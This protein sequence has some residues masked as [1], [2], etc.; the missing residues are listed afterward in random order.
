MASSGSGGT[1]TSLSAFISSLIVNLIV[2]AVFLIIFVSLRKKQARVYEPRTTVE[3]VPADLVPDENPRGAFSW[4]TH[5]LKKPEAFIIQQA[6]VDGYFFIRFLFEFCVVCYGGAIITWPILFPV[7]AT[8]SNHLTEFNMLAFGNVKHKWRYLAHIFMS[9]IFFGFVLFLIYRELVY[10]TTFR[11]VVQT[12]PLYDSLLSSRTLL[13]TEV[14]ENALEEGEL[15]TYFPTATNV[16]YARDYAELDEKVKERTKL[17]SKYEGALNKVISTAVKTRAK[18]IKKNKEPPS[19]VDDINK[20]LKDGKK[21]PT[22]RLKFLIGKKVDTLNYGAERLGE[23]NKEIKKNQ[24]ECHANTQIPSV[25]IEFPTQLELQKAY[26]A[27][28][29]NTDFKNTKRH[30]GLAPDDVI[31]EN[32]SL[33]TNKRRIKKII[34]NVVLTLMIIFWAIPVAVVGAISNINFLISKVHFLSFINNLPSFLLGLITGL[35]PVVALAI[36]MSL[37]PPFIRKMGKVAGCITVQ[38]VESFCQAWYYAFQVVHVFLV[39]TLA[40]SATSVVTAVIDEPSSA[41][42]LLAEKIPPASN[43]YI[44]YLCLQGLAVSSGL[45]VQIV[46]LILSQFLGKILDSTP[47]AKWTRWNTLG[48]PAWSTVYPAYQLLVV[49]ALCYAVIAPLVLGFTAVAFTLI[50]FAYVYTLTYVLQPNKTDARGRNYPSALFQMF[51]G[52]YL[53]EVCLLAMFVFTK[54]WVCVALE[55]VIL[56]VTIGCHV[57]YKRIF[58]PL[59]DIVPISALKYASGDNTFQYP[60]H[61]QGLKEIKSEGENY[62]QGGNQLGLTGDHA[63]QVLPHLDNSAASGPAASTLDNH[64]T[65]SRKPINDK[66]SDEKLAEPTYETK[67]STTTAGESQEKVKPVGWISR[68]FHP[69][70]ESFD[71]LRKVMPQVLFNYIEYND[72]FI[73]TAYEDPAVNDDEPHIWIPRDELGLSEIQKNLALEQGVDVSDGNAIFNEKNSIEYTGPPPSYEE[74]LKI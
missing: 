36:L 25:F 10:Y 66:S 24:L 40:S 64:S 52:L 12:T 72:D 23:L 32:L 68:F 44:A 11:H 15:R 60:S 67:A 73:K 69:K 9:W 18:A 70:T 3:T 7:N 30:T 48:Q 5:V 17:A 27:I 33:T 46:G 53:A 20:Y 19:P 74:A 41:L 31:W 28:P 34:A 56:A 13:L 38:Q 42:K 43:F 26:Q 61:D 6:G 57:Y 71:L 55:A 59:F 62:W 2:F 14:P 45:L 63:D 16:W 21:R 22:H 4:L 39:V 51:V 1:A 47:R 58:L 65:D 49:I 54:N 8:N 37:V 29:Y 50:Y 35:L